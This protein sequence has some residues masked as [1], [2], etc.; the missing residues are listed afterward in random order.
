MPT[1]IEGLWEALKQRWGKGGVGAPYI[2]DREEF[3]RFMDEWVTEHDAELMAQRIDFA[4][5]TNIADS[6]DDLAKAV[7]RSLD[8]ARL[9]HDTGLLAESNRV[10]IEAELAPHTEKEK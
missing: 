5:F 3:V 2:L 10:A 6:V 8:M 7:R 1:D 4:T 9:Q